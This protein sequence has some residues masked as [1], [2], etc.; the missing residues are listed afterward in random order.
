MFSSNKAIISAGVC[1]AL[2]LAARSFYSLS[3]TPQTAPEVQPESRSATQPRILGGSA[4]LPNGNTALGNDS[5]ETGSQPA[6]SGTTIPQPTEQPQIQAPAPSIE[7]I[8][9]KIVSAA[10]GEPEQ[11]DMLNLPAVPDN[12]ISIDSTGA[13]TR[14]EYLVYF[15]THHSDIVFDGLRFEKVLKDENKIPLLPFRLAEQALKDEGAST[16]YDSLVVFKDFIKAKIIYEGH[17]KVSGDA[18]T[19]NKKIIAFDKL[20]LEL[21]DKAMNIELGVAAKNDMEIFS[22]K[23]GATAS[24]EHDLLLQQ[25]G[26]IATNNFFENFFR[27]TLAFLGAEKALAAIGVPFGGLATVIVPCICSAGTLVTIGPPVPAELFVSIAWA[28]TP[29]FFLYKALHPGAWWLGLYEPAPV[30][31]LEPAPPPAMCLPIGA[32]VPPTI[33]GTSP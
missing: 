27:K 1:I 13:K 32:G 16:T 7:E 33:A 23:F 5:E 3:R 19:L 15:S 24:F 26:M 17:I 2:L 21:I 12:E 20:T 30:P 28:A 29:V 4:F 9:K 6:V 14:E 11:E 22:Q 25:T 18:I 10:S 31:C 8:R